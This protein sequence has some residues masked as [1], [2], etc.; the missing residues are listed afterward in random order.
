MTEITN[1]PAPQ[2]K[3]SSIG[4]TA[5][6]AAQSSDRRTL[7]QRV[8]DAIEASPAPLIPEDILA[9]LRAD[10]VKTVLTSIRPRCSELARAGFIR[11]SGQRRPGEGGC[12]AI[13]WRATTTAERAEWAAKTSGGDA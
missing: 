6:C 9:Q 10:G 2:W 7:R 1:H 11:D 3:R 12:S 13:A 8:L 4:E 5:Q